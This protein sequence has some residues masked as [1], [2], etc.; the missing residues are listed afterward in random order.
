MWGGVRVVGGRGWG[1][2]GEVDWIC[3]EKRDRKGQGRE[4]NWLGGYLREGG[5][6]EE[7]EEEKK[8]V[9]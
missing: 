6:G 7:G 8:R 9:Q 5:G 3:I 2:G 4:K 1:L